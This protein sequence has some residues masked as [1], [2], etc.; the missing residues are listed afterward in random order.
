MYVPACA[1]VL[2][3]L[4][5][6][7]QVARGVWFGPTEVPVTAE[8]ALPEPAPE[9]GMLAPHSNLPP[10]RGPWSLVWVLVT[11]LLPFLLSFVLVLQQT[12][13]GRFPKNSRV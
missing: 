5:P 4:V 13:L 3:A 12:P 11:S 2:T 10:V 7:N 1:R 8:A 9:R 6:G